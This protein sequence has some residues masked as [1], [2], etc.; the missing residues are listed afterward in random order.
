ML[1]SLY[2]SQAS[3][4]SVHLLFAFVFC[5]VLL[6]PIS[7]KASWCFCLTSLLIRTDCSAHLGK[8]NLSLSNHQLSR[9]PF[10]FRHLSYGA[11]W[12]RFMKNCLCLD[13]VC[14]QQ[15]LGCLNLYHVHQDRKMRLL[16]ALCRESHPYDWWDW[17]HKVVQFQGQSLQGVWIAVP[18]CWMGRCREDRARVSMKLYG[19]EPSVNTHIWEHEKFQLGLMESFLT[20]TMLKHWNVV[21]RSSE[22]FSSGFPQDLTGKSPEQT[23]LHEPALRTGLDQ[24]TFSGP[25]QHKS[26]YNFCLVSGK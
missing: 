25:F 11:L 14:L 24:V 26:S 19:E 23:D 16:P 2:S 3:C 17:E 20:E 18:D 12:S 5:P 10:N 1:G 6:A 22:I 8:V 7:M 9:I 13:I 15:V 4:H 21:Q